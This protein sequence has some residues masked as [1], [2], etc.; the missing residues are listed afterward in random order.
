MDIYSK[1]TPLIQAAISIGLGLLFMLTCLSF[2][3]TLALRPEKPWVFASTFLLF[4]AI[5]NIVF[6]FNAENP[7]KYWTQ[8]V[9]GFVIS[10]LGLSLFAYLI[11]GLSINNA[12][13][14]RWI[15]IV[16]TVSYLVFMSMARAMRFIVEFAQKEEWN[17]PKLRD[18]KKKKPR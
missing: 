15:F 3:E 6:S 9:I 11:S 14:I 1:V 4:Y 7:E 2:E 5:F 18:R 12:G 8:A 16:I 10:V 17:Q 13:S